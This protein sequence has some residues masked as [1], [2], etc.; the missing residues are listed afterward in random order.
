M[1]CILP[2]ILLAGAPLLLAEPAA[3]TTPKANQKGRP[4]TQALG[5]KEVLRAAATIDQLLEND[6][7]DRELKPLPIVPD[8]IFVRR[9]YLT[10]VGRIPTPQEAASFLD[11][12]A[13]DKRTR[14]IE[15]LA[16]SPGYD[17]SAFNYFADL[18]RL[19]TTHEQYGLG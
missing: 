2:A 5:L 18:L 1:K 16:N 6:L 19:Q 9:S 12:K 3:R 13:P 8:D 15:K 7:A 11:D 14:L 4:V 17:S 10:I